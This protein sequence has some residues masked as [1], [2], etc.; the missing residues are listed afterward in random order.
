MI[1]GRGMIAKEFELF[2]DS[3]S[4]LIFASGV[5]NSN[6]VQESEFNR[7]KE[8]LISNLK[9]LGNKRIV[10]FSTC[11]VYDTYFCNNPYT[12]HKLN[13]ESIIVDRANKYIIF[14]LPQ[15]LGVNNEH[16]LMGFLFDKI[17]NNDVFKLYDIERNI[18]DSS[19]VKLLVTYIVT[20]ELFENQII[21]IA[22]PYN[23]KVKD[24]VLEIESIYGYMAKYTNVKLNGDFVIDTS[25]ISDIIKELKLFEH[26]YIQKRIRKYY[27]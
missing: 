14:R 21:N 11:S 16:Q 18:I 2:K 24:L 9:H 7:E 22:N 5:S 10:Y 13:M 25:S 19:D 15:V 3:N 12:Q 4:I 26:N 6:E 27:G 1:I 20:H 17:K 23:I 8:L